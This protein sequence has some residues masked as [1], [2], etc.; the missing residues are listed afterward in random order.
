MP[1]TPDKI[2]HYREIL[3]ERRS[4][5]VGQVQSLAEDVVK[6]TQSTEHS[7]SPLSLAENAS[8]AFEQDFAFITMESE[9]ELVRKIDGA[10]RRIREGTYG[11]CDEC[12]AAI[13]RERLEVLP[14]ADLCMK[15][16]QQ[17]ETTG[18]RKRDDD[19]EMLD[20]DASNYTADDD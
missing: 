9:E 15:C 7:K 8:D 3:L 20:D 2:E 12:G 13:N 4:A 18:R 14:F 16:Q 11:D 19:F 17:E 5:L 6:S 1:I 10:L